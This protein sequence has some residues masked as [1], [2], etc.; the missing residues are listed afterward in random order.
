VKVSLKLKRQPLPKR[1]KL[2]QLSKK[3]LKQQIQKLQKKNQKQL[4]RKKRKKMKK[5]SQQQLKE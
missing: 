4:K 5:G 1:K 2:L 3:V